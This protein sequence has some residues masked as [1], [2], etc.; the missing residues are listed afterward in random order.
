M[1]TRNLTMIIKD[2][3]VRLSQYGQ[4]DGYFSYT[5]IKF[6]KFVKN[7]LQGKSPT[8]HK[9]LMERFAEKVD[10]LEQVSEEYYE[11]LMDKILPFTKWDDKNN[12]IIP[13]NT[14][15]PQFSRDTGVGIL[16]IVNGLN[17]YD[18]NTFKKFPVDIYKDTEGYC[19]YANVINM[20][21]DEIYMLTIHYFK[22]EPQTTCE[23]LENFL[24]M[25][26]YYKSNIMCVP[27]IENCKRLVKG[28]EL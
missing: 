1:G 27:S 22:G 5:G 18:F 24:G 19:E 6:L 21:T 17:K 2:N 15:L 26:C 23:L 4:W 12:Y 28:L 9:D 10:L 25:K 8:T 11:N 7:N 20:D 14:I 16:D 13:F 3:K